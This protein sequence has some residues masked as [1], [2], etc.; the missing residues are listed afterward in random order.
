[1]LSFRGT[2]FEITYVP[3][4][5]AF[6]AVY[7]ETCKVWRLI[8]E[9]VNLSKELGVVKDLKE[10]G[11]VGPRYNPNSI[12]YGRQLAFYKLMCVSAK[13]D[14]LVAQ[15]KAALAADKSVVIALQST[16]EAAQ[17]RTAPSKT[18]TESFV[19]AVGLM[20]T[21]LL[22]HKTLFECSK[23]QE[24]DNMKEELAAAIDAL[25][26]QLPGNP[27][28]IIIDRLGGTRKVAEMTGRGFRMARNDKNELV[29]QKRAMVKNDE[30]VADSVNIQERAWFQAGRKRVAIISDAASTGISLHAVRTLTVVLVCCAP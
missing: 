8:V 10:S 18:G 11:V 15:C 29:L 14:T 23:Y 6:S 30:V 26:P 21:E 20:L 24:L 1:M 13:V 3:E 25:L 5:P 9:F 17:T 27:L 4:D 28:D 12:I 19:S 22:G 2:S 16:G 7:N